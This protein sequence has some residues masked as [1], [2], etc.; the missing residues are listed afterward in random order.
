M[1]W[2]GESSLFSVS[3]HLFRPFQSSSAGNVPRTDDD[4][5]LFNRQP[6]LHKMSIMGH[7]V[8]IMPYSSFRLNLSCTTPYNAD[9]DGDEMNLHVPQS[10]ETRA[11]A[12]ELMLVQRQIVTPASNRPVISVVQDALLGA[13]NFT[14]R[15]TFLEKVG[16]LPSQPPGRAYALATHQRLLLARAT[17]IRL[18]MIIKRGPLLPPS[19]PP[20]S[21]R[22]ARH[23][24]DLM[25]N[26][27]MWLVNW[28]G[29]IPEP[30]I[31]KPR[32]LWTG[33][34]LF[35]ML[36]PPNINLERTSAWHPTEKEPEYKDPL[37]PLDTVVLIEDSELVC[38]TLCKKSLGSG[39][40]L[41]PGTRARPA[42]RCGG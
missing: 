22:C 14:K 15:D 17:H 7:R 13:R 4:Y 26:C 19:V 1:G 21:A 2:E 6:S 37:Y 34:Q 23:P 39:T 28:D 41:H 16:A 38:G 5:I 8:K 30:A 3:H 29:T 10:L 32:P 35:S 18:R 42:A 11:E 40:G 12:R 27:L 31:L 9:F 36:L 33:K 20:F 25:M 24:Q